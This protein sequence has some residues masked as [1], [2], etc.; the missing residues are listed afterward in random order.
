MTKTQVM[1]FIDKLNFRSF[2]KIFHEVQKKF[3]NVKKKILRKWVEEIW[4]DTLRNNKLYMVKIFSRTPGSYNMDLMDNGKGNNPRYWYIFININTR[5]AIAYPLQS[6]S[7]EDIRNVLSDFINKYKPTKLTSDQEAGINSQTTQIV[8]E[9]NHTSLAIIDRFIRTLRDLNTPSDKSKHQSTHIKYTYL[10]HKRMRKLLD[11][12]NSTY[13]TTIKCT[14]EEMQNDP[15]KEKDYIFKCLDSKR[16][17]SGMKDMELK[18]GSYV[19]Y[20]IPKEFMKKRRYYSSRECYQIAEV[21][22]NMYTIIA[23]DGSVKNLPRHRLIQC[24]PDG[25]KPSNIKFAESFPGAWNGLIQSVVG[26]N[27]QSNHYRVIFTIPNKPRGWA[28][29]LPPSYLSKQDKLNAPI[30]TGN[31]AANAAEALRADRQ[32]ANDYNK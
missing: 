5:Y 8:T 30:V 11:K 21:K 15:N 9:Q 20:L 3:P 26:F 32:W 12:Y 14:P 27:R 17:Q 29:V 4:H 1:N 31:D 10:S 22:G 13:H 16:R 18:K 2:N 24:K 28:D 25:S 7:A 23:Q 19:F 6:K